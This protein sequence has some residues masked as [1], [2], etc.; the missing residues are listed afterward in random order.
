MTDAH[1]PIAAQEEWLAARKELQAEEKAHT[2]EYDR[3]NA[4]RRR[5]PMV[6]VEKE[7]RFHGEDGEKSLGDLFEGKK[8][9]VVYHFMF[10]PEW[11]EGC[12]SCTGFVDALGDLSYVDECDTRMILVSR[13]PY[14]KLKAYRERRGW[15]LPWYSSGDGDFNYD[16]HGTLDPARG[17]IEYN[18]RTEPELDEVS[19]RP[20]LS[21]FF[22]IG[23]EVYHTYSVYARG[24]EGITD[25]YKILDITPFGRQQDFEDSPEGWPQH[26][27]YG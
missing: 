15:T 7:Y 4:K 18:Y 25:S 17:A 1:P 20:G 22:R 6:E 27:T 3:I 26:P 16:F 13:A 11:D 9:L 8:Q 12:P 23:D 2:R 19:D 10:A 14:E 5:L 21:V 24:L